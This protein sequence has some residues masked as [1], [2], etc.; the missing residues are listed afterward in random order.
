M[1]ELEDMVDYSQEVAGEEELERQQMQ[2]ELNEMMEEEEEEAAAA[3]VDLDVD[4]EEVDLELDDQVD[5]RVGPDT[6]G[7]IDV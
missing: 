1:A 4:A 2:E 3:A 7:S 5:P 6:F